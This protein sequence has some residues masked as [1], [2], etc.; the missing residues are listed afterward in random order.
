MWPRGS[1]E[2]GLQ[3][4]LFCLVHLVTALTDL[5][6]KTMVEKHNFYRSRADPQAADMKALRWDRTLEDLAI[7]YAAKCI[8]DHNEERGFRGENLFLMTG[9]SLDVE[10]GMA[11][12][13]RERDYYNFTSD[14]CQEGQMCGHY[15]QVRLQRLP[16]TLA[17]PY[18]HKPVT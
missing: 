4:F 2:Q 8:W 3:N 5:E 11:D 14:T 1:R 7:S 9:S 10:L 12:W 15:T 16:S 17:E 18:R 6:K 13:H